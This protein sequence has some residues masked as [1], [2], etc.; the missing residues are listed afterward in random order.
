VLV[1]GALLA[2]IH[3]FSDTEDSGGF[4]AY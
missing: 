4:S 3:F 2:Y 1:Y